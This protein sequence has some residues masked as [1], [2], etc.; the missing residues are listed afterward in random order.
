MLDPS[1]D[2]VFIGGTTGNKYYMEKQME[3]EL[4]MP[5]AQSVDQLVEADAAIQPK[6]N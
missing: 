3:N 6:S 2:D 4:V 5:A 1:C